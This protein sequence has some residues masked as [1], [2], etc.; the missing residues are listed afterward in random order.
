M[1]QI[2]NKNITQEERLALA[3]KLDADLD[4]FIN[5]LEKKRYTDGW[6]PD[7]WEKVRFVI[8]NTS[9]SNMCGGRKVPFLYYDN[10]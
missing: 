7:N 9:R 10:Q 6:T 4:A 3:A 1:D 5:S 8:E 2:Q